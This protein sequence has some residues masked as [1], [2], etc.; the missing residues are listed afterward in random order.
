M[1]FYL[2]SGGMNNNAPDT[3]IGL[4][5]LQKITCLWLVYQSEIPQFFLFPLINNG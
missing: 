4:S 2:A 1:F 3:V 5:K